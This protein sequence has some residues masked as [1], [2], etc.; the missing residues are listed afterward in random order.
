[1]GSA[2]H[3]NYPTSNKE[4]ELHELP[5]VNI[6]SMMLLD[7]SKFSILN[8]S[9]FAEIVDPKGNSVLKTDNY[10]GRSIP[11]RT[12]TDLGDILLE[13][14]EE[15]QFFATYTKPEKEDC[16]LDEFV[17]MAYNNKRNP[18]NPKLSRSLSNLLFRGN[19][20]P[21]GICGKLDILNIDDNVYLALT[22]LDDQNMKVNGLSSW[23][24]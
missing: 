20:E 9:N 2:V 14:N 22:K 10:T 17:S 21:V 7:P 23:L 16:S 4:K 3:P 5:K 1:M 13:K 24:L 11:T 19:N 8:E 12:L 15:G 6:L 18:K